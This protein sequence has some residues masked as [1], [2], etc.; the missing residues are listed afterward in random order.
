LVRVS[1]FTAYAAGFTAV[2][3]G[4]VSDVGI[5]ASCA[6]AGGGIMGVAMRKWVAWMRGLRR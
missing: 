2:L 5:V 4:C 6:F 3:A 1:G